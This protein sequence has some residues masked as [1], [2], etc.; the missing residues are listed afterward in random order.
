MAEDLFGELA[1]TS[2]YWWFVV[3]FPVCYYV[4]IFVL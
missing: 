4:G 2:I 3:F 1:V